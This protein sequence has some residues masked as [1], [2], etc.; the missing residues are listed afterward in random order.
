MEITIVGWYGTETIGDRT[1]LAGLFNVLSEVFPQ[2]TV[3]LGSL[4]PF[5]TEKT[6][7]E[8]EAFYKKASS[9]KLISISVFNSRSPQQLSTN[10]KHSNLVMVGGGPLMDLKEMNMLEYAFV[11]A[12]KNKIKTCLMGCGWGPLKDERIIAKAIHLVEM[13]DVVIFRD[14]IS[15]EE[16]LKA[17]DKYSEKIH[18]SIDPAFFACHFYLQHQV[19]YRKKTHIAINFRDIALEGTHYSATA[20]PESLFAEIA[21]SIASNTNLMVY[22]VP[23][24]YFAIGGD[25]REILDRIEK[26]LNL[27]NLKTIHTPLS[28]QE[29]MDIYYHAFMCLGMR[30]HS[31]VLQTMLNGNNYIVDYTNPQNGKIIGMMN[32]LRLHPFYDSRYYSIHT[33][34][35]FLLPRLNDTSHYQYDANMIEKEKSIYHNLLRQQ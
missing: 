3:H 2:F 4:Y 26:T 23:M 5:F 27:P 14:S 9:N 20:P 33:A 29:T 13:A 7:L 1:I 10:I 18:S 28:L 35:R 24:H 22:L 31:I 12:K 8:D 34:G 30:F 15:K 19:E 25:D 32:Q 17:C 6:I 11:K 21:K 16:C